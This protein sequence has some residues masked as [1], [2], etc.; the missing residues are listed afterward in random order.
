MININQTFGGNVRNIQHN[1][2]NMSTLL[3]FV[4]GT[5][6]KNDLLLLDQNNDFDIIE[7]S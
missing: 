1:I 4:N 2:L 6:M 5:R 7:Y 3:E